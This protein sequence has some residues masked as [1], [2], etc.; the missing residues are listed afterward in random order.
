[1]QNGGMGT[2]ETRVIDACLI[3]MVYRWSKEGEKERKQ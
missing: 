1:M 2:M 3:I